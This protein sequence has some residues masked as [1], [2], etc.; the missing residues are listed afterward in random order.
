[1]LC[2]GILCRRRFVECVLWLLLCVVLVLRG[3]QLFLRG[4]TRVSMF[5]VVSVSGGFC[6]VLA[7]SSLYEAVSFLLSFWVGLL[8]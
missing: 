4:L 3:F 1:M 7:I 5:I 2:V 8:A 6:V